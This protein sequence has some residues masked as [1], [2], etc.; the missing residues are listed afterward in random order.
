MMSCS[1]NARMMKN[2][3]RMCN[4]EAANA[5]TNA[6]NDVAFDIADS[7]RGNSIDQCLCH[8]MAA[9]S[10]ADSDS[11]AMYSTISICLIDC[12]EDDKMLNNA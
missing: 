2:G 9:P 8:C 10:I 12:S 5:I 7:E 3:S 4:K 11:L 1:A 6:R